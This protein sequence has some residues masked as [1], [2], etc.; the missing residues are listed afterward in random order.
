M[1]AREA[2]KRRLVA[3]R[4]AICDGCGRAGPVEMHE[5]FVKRSDVPRRRQAQIFAEWN[6]VLLCPACHRAHGQT[7]QM[8][9]YLF[10]LQTARGYDVPG[11]MALLDVKVRQ[12]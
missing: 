10:A 12:L 4:G 7:K 11:A 1:T 6:C 5:A 3:T 9:A 8:K 2:L